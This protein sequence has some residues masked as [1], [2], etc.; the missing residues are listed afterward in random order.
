MNCIILHTS[1]MLVIFIPDD[2]ADA[3]TAHDHDRFN[4]YCK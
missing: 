3:S 4:Q 1:V 2:K